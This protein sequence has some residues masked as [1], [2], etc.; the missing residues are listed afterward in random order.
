MNGSLAAN[1]QL[2]AELLQHDKFQK[3]NNN[4][5]NQQFGLCVPYPY[6][7]QVKTAVQATILNLGAQDVSDH[8]RPE[9]S[10]QVLRVEQG[11]HA[12]PRSR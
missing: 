11:R 4:P 8:P 5:N 9:A 6:L 2:L 10:R 12:S 7:S 1:D 3:K